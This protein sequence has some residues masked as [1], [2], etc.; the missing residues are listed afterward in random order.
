MRLVVAAAI[1]SGIGFA[2]VPTIGG[3]ALCL[4]AVD[5]SIRVS[6]YEGN[7]TTRCATPDTLVR[8]DVEVEV[9]ANGIR[10]SGRPVSVL[11]GDVVSVKPASAIP[12][13]FVVFRYR[14]VDPGTK[15]GPFTIKR[16]T[17][18]MEPQTLAA[19]EIQIGVEEDPVTHWMLDQLEPQ[20]RSTR[21]GPLVRL[22]PSTLT[23]RPPP[24]DRCTEDDPAPSHVR[25][26]VTIVRPR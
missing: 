8:S 3:K 5:G 14:C 21:Y 16:A 4:G 9:G 1:A 10:L 12:S 2:S 26:R 22:K 15:I 19:G 17:V 25:L 18:K 7:R 11:P 24:R 23:R 6:V 20:H 13:T